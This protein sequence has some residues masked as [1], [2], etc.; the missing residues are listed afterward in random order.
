M[1]GRAVI[2]HLL[3]WP[4]IGGTE[5]GT[6]RLIQSVGS[7]EFS[8]LAFVPRGAMGLIDLCSRHG[9]DCVE[10][11]A[12]EPSIR[13][14]APFFRASLALGRQL[15]AHRVRLAHAADLLGAFYGSLAGPL[16]GIPLTT[17]VRCQYPVLS[18]RDRQFLWSVRHYCF[19][20]ADA[21]RAF[22]KPLPERRVSIVGDAL[23]PAATPGEPVVNLRA[24]LNLPT[25]AVLLGMVARVAAAKDFSTLLAAVDILR[26]DR[27]NLYLVVIGDYESMPEYRQHYTAVLEELMARRLE[28]RVFFIGPL[29]SLDG[30]WE[31]LTVSVLVTHTEGL[32]LVILE[33]MRG[34]CP[35]VATRVGGI[36]E[37][38]VEGLNG[39][40]HSPGNAPELATQ[41]GRLIDDPEYADALVARARA[42]VETDFSMVRYGRIMGALFRRWT[43]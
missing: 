25:D 1:S 16:A 7:E 42:S 35:V 17:H 5:W 6:V 43:Q 20:S 38:I 29:P 21:R 39:L 10:Y 30:I 15:R 12:H 11:V 34:G 9:V 4:T 26:A 31:Q 22:G 40:L 28:G 27:P 13:S 33:A 24:R 37:I 19:V 41:V 23:G 8:H 2:A 3:P 14:G 18:W 32:P 36:P